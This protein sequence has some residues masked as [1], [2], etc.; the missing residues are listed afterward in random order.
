MNVGKSNKIT[1]VIEVCNLS[2]FLSWRRSSQPAVEDE[3]RNR[4]TQQMQKERDELRE[5]EEVLRRKNQRRGAR[6]QEYLS[7]L[8]NKLQQATKVKG[9]AL[10]VETKS[11]LEDDTFGTDTTSTEASGGSTDMV[12]RREQV[13]ENGVGLVAGYVA[14]GRSFR[15]GMAVSEMHFAG[16]R[17]EECN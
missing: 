11:G 8:G 13:S 1:L 12:L 16:C 6:H 2:R 10:C 5:L 4:L 15:A 14:S 7:E 3:E 17:C 9:L